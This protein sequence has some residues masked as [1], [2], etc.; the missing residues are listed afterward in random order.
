MC[1]L[2][3]PGGINT[4]GRSHLPNF[5][6]SI[7][8]VISV[9]TENIFCYRMES[10]ITPQTNVLRKMSH[11]LLTPWARSFNIPEMLHEGCSPTRKWLF[12]LFLYFILTGGS[13]FK[14]SPDTDVC[15]S[16]VLFQMAKAINSFITS[17][18]LGFRSRTPVSV[19]STLALPD[20]LEPLENYISRIIWTC[21]VP[22]IVVYTSLYL[23]MIISRSCSC[24]ST[25]IPEDFYESPKPRPPPLSHHL[26][27]AFTRSTISR[28]R[29]SHW[30]G[31][32]FFMGPFLLVLRSYER[33][34][35]RD[36]IGHE[37]LSI[38]SGLSVNDLKDL[39]SSID[40]VIGKNTKL[41][42]DEMIE[43]KN[44][45]SLIEIECPYITARRMQ[46]ARRKTLETRRAELLASA[47]KET[48]RSATALLLLHDVFDINAPTISADLMNKPQ[49]AMCPHC[50]RKNPGCCPNIIHFVLYKRL[51]ALFQTIVFQTHRHNRRIERKQFSHFFSNIIYMII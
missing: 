9:P 7:L 36:V 23:L 1:F 47:G 21:Q 19:S 29:K 22:N 11:P 33:I 39:E 8:P 6:P 10:K 13:V 50:K 46:E 25:E 31:C 4:V 42:I 24:K 41:T 5:T 32:H 49:T 3:L 28:V 48:E 34:S 45:R 15:Q 43:K 14:S 27:Q 44:F 16:V 37:M 18:T 38:I 20:T 12:C 51:Q 26:S 2:E 17:T 35:R 30:V 40:R